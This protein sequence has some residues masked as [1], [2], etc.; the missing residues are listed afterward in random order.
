M[1]DMI[2]ASL[3]I[4]VYCTSRVRIEWK[5]FV[6]LGLNNRLDAVEREITNSG[7]L[8]LSKDWKNTCKVQLRSGQA[9][10]IKVR[11]SQTIHSPSFELL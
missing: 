6:G 10:K 2:F 3:K 11:A 9:S 4:Q 7:G 8:N 1:T 5:V